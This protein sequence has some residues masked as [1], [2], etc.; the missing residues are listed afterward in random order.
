MLTGSKAHPGLMATKRTSPS[1]DPVAL[2]ASALATGAEVLSGVTD[3]Q[4]DLP[5][6]C[7]DFDVRTLANHLL[8]A[9]FSIAALGRGEGYAERPV[10]VPHD[11]WRAD[12]EASTAAVREVWSD[13]AL[14][15]KTIALPWAELP[16]AAV[17]A[18]F[19]GEVVIH[20]W[21][22][23]QATGQWAEWQPDVLALSYDAFHE[24]LPA[25]GREA[26]AAFGDVVAVPDDAPVI[27]RL[28]A[29]T[30]RRP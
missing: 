26:F 13:D 16:G 30:G 12:W 21:D 29:W 1:P 15:G 27:D 9:P 3:E 2:F 5:T 24:G 23:A 6:P 28:V 7:T 19:T 25:E 18:Q 22:L 14:L 11:E 10:L 4:L 8:G 20:T 17:L